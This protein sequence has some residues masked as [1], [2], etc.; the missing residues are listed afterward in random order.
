MPEINDAFD[1]VD[2]TCWTWIEQIVERFERAWQ[3]GRRPVL[4]DY[5][6]DGGDR[7]GLLKQLV[8]ADLECRLRAGESARVEDYLQRFPE[9]QQARQ[10]LLDL[11]AHEFRLRRQ[12]E[13]ADQRSLT[14]H[15]GA[16]IPA[17][18]MFPALPGYEV[19]EQLGRGGM[20]VVFKAWQ[21]SLKRFVAL[22]MLCDGSLVDAEQRARFRAEAES[23][24]HLRHPNIVQIYEI[25]EHEGRPYLALEYA[26]GGSLARRLA[27]GPLLWR[28]AAGLIE[29]I[30]RAMHV[31]HQA[32]I[33]HRDLTPANILLAADGSPRISDFGLAKRLDGESAK[34]QTGAIFGTPSYMA[35]EQAS[36]QGKRAGVTTDVYALGAILYELLAGRPPFRAS[37]PLETLNQVLSEEPRTP[38]RFA[39]RL[40]RDL[41]T[42]CLKCLC[43]VP[44]QRYASALELAEDLRRW[45]DGEPI[46]ARSTPLWGRLAKWTRRRPAAALLIVSLFAALALAGGVVWSTVEG[47]RAL[48][49]GRQ[50]EI[51]ARSKDELARKHQSE[52]RQQMYSLD[53]RAAHQ[54]WRN[55]QVGQAM[56]RL[57]T[58]RPQGNAAEPVGFAWH[59]LWRLCQDSAPTCSRSDGGEVL[60]LTF[61][62]D[63]VVLA[64]AHADGSVCLW[65]TATRQLR[66]T[67]HGHR[68]AVHWL[69]FAP[70]GKSLYST[71]ADR[72]VRV[73]DVEQGVQTRRMAGPDDQALRWLLSPDGRLLAVARKDGSIR[74]HRTAGGKP[75]SFGAIPEEVDVLTFAADGRT[76]GCG[77]RGHVFLW[78]MDAAKERAYFQHTSTIS[79]LTLTQDGR[80]VAVAEENG[81]ITLHVLMGHQ[82]ISFVGNEGVTRCLAFAPDD[83]LLASVGDDNVI[84]LWDV[85]TGALRNAIRV[86][87]DRVHGLAFSPD[88]RW[89][90]AA[91]RD[92]KVRF[93]EPEARQD[94]DALLAASSARTR[95]AWAPDGRLAAT[96]GQDRAVQ[97]WDASTWREAGRLVG[98][99]GDVHDLAF[100]L[101]SRVLAT[102]SSDRTV[103]LWDVVGRQRRSCLEHSA[104]VLS[105]ALHP[106]NRTLAAGT[107]DGEV[108]L[109]DCIRGVRLRSL[110]SHRAGVTALAFAPN[111]LALA[112][113]SGDR[114]VQLWD[115]TGWQR[116]LTVRCDCGIV[117]VAFSPDSRTLAV[118]ETD[119]AVMLWD[120]ASGACLSRLS[121]HNSL[122]YQAAH[123]SP[124]G[125]TMV[126]SG[127]ESNLAVWD[128]GNRH[129]PVSRHRL[130]DGGKVVSAA[131][132]PDGKNLAALQWSGRITLWD[133]VR[134]KARRPCGPVL[135]PVRALAFSP[136]GTILATVS[137]TTAAG[138]R[139]TE[140]IWPV[141]RPIHRDTFLAGPCDEA[142]RF[143]DAANRQPLR[144]LSSQP[145][146]TRP[147]LLAFAPDGRTLATA[148]DGG[149]VWLWELT[150]ARRRAVLY[151]GPRARWL[152]LGEEAILQGLPFHTQYMERI[153]ALAF[154]PDGRTLGIVGPDGTLQLWDATTG[155][156]CAILS[157]ERPEANCLAFAPDGRT[158][159]AHY[160]GEVELWDVD[161]RQLL[162]TRLLHRGSVIR[163]LA[164]SPDGRLL[165]SGASDCGVKLW[166]W[167]QDRQFLLSGH[168]DSVSAAAFTPDGRTLATSGFDGTVR[169]WDVATAQEVISLAG[170]TG[171]VHCLAF[172][173]DGQTLASGGETP[174]GSGEVYFWRTARTNTTDRQR[175]ESVHSSSGSG[176][177]CTRRSPNDGR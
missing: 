118:T 73:W 54:F 94:R 148:Q 122:A 62:P 72:T 53:V 65:T 149:T 137:E 99:F 135:E 177:N 51:E 22:K 102:A 95:L 58:H 74:V 93:W 50:K 36:G 90:V 127:R 138:A 46:H 146:V 170:H 79:G 89:L 4:D 157:S 5:L 104:A 158:L 44:Q 48:E 153:L 70:D 12:G 20:G 160:R 107:N 101:D 123:F 67:L 91:G 7:P 111:G 165:A 128:V 140:S 100:S 28:E 174:H 108:I 156:R 131:F 87:T 71:G 61:A 173:P 66:A 84:R 113:A 38:R 39:A 151:V 163:Y 14:V 126:L 116:G 68:G 103:Q 86:P 83:S 169:L 23:V 88:G 115:T 2:S 19:V 96:L 167:H 75:L 110:G 16:E 76:L 136:D 129:K 161:K 105:V 15:D 11:L 45:Q 3:S 119:G 166:D 9:L 144:L 27:R 142:L 18:P 112:S 147:A 80:A 175:L 56:A 139:H 98:H 34:T 81:K 121:E 47:E 78:D 155:E 24:A 159:A 55:G 40:P 82:T 134:W 35:P 26:E 176:R 29:T 1:K 21:C 133:A 109:W 52:L 57:E 171:K 25:D 114:T 33:I 43:K 41:E 125:R 59:Y 164:F 49:Y 172:T 132:A 130:W 150:A 63:G 42:I 85:H 31:A 60:A 10:T 64:T 120:A 152:S 13:A 97:L 37:T 168:N 141:S 124:D 17:V 30:A 69:S 6:I 8:Q 117:H 145:A 32:G 162:Q 154:A 77:R 92:G 143:W 106:D